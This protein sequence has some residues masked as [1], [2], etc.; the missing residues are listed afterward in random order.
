MTLELLERP[1][2]TILDA[3]TPP[4]GPHQDEEP[5]EAPEGDEE[6]K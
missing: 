5:D 6:E 2:I 3:F 4:T 1:L